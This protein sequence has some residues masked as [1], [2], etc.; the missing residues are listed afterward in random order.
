MYSIFL[1][2]I[3][4]LN[5]LKAIILWLN[6]SNFFMTLL[7]ISIMI[8]FSNLWLC[9]A[10]WILL[11]E[12]EYYFINLLVK[13]HCKILSPNLN[14]FYRCASFLI[15]FIPCFNNVLVKF[16]INNCILDDSYILFSL[17]SLSYFLSSAILRMSFYW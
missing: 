14:L 12:Y 2:N 15:F 11:K 7:Y 9:L 10:F 3:F 16:F 5:L 8:P 13:M 4:S 17:L 1:K 6:P